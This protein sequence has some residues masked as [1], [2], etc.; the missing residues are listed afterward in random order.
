[1]KLIDPE[2]K[3]EFENFLVNESRLSEKSV[4][5]YSQAIYGSIA[6]WIDRTYEVFEVSEIEK[7]VNEIKELPDFK[8][9]NFQ[10]NGMYNASL[11]YLGKFLNFK[12]TNEKVLETKKIEKSSGKEGDNSTESSRPDVNLSNP[13]GQLSIE[14]VYKEIEDANSLDTETRGS[15]RKE[16]RK[17]RDIHIPE[18]RTS[19]C[20]ICGSELPS[21]LL[22]AAHIKKRSK[23]SLE[24]K[25]DLANIATPMCLL[26]CD[27]LFEKG[28]I[29]VRNGV[30]ER[31]KETS[32]SHAS[33]HISMVTG[34]SCKDWTDENRKYYEWHWEFHS[35]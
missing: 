23:C 30:T 5:N 2:L 13:Q 35:E 29:G 25:K 22:V 27:A 26:G 16:Q 18:N 31:I 1:M 17:L 15:G 28:Y 8:K 9:F 7:S 12:L 10:G 20:S 6:N 24:E 4:K 11:N 32:L 21:D 3:E 14:E 34:E 33:S 19:V